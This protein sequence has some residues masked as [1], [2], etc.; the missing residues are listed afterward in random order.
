MADSSISSDSGKLNELNKILMDSSNKIEEAYAKWDEL[1]EL[2][3]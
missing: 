2:L 1:S 3:Q